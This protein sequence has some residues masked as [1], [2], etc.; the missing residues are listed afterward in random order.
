MDQFAQIKTMLTSFPGP[1]QKTTRTAFCNY[2]A[3]EVE[4][5]EE[6]KFETFRNEPV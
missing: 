1:R 3:S 6:R 4:N 2:L 5:L